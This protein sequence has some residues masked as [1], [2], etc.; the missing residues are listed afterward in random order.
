[1]SG[2]FSGGNET[3]APA[4]VV[5]PAPVVRPSPPVP[6]GDV[7]GSEAKELKRVRKGVGTTAPLSLLAAAS[8]DEPSLTGTLGG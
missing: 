2:I 6:A 5:Q 8:T 4:P 7:D 1:M 3:A